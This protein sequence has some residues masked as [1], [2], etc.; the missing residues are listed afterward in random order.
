MVIFNVSF[1]NLYW[2]ALFYG[3]DYWYFLGCNHFG[4]LSLYGLVGGIGCGFTID[5]VH[6]PFVASGVKWTKKL[7][8]FVISVG[9]TLVFVVPLFGLV[10]GLTYVLNTNVLLFNDEASGMI[11]FNWNQRHWFAFW[12]ALL[13]VIVLNYV[14]G[15]LVGFWISFGVP[16]ICFKLNRGIILLDE[17]V[18]CKL[19]SIPTRDDGWT[20]PIQEI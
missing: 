8:R 12:S 5:V 14:L 6:F 16:W 3:Y 1:Q 17:V 10:E 15:L 19:L 4:S 13:G 2:S 9:L 18:Y 11:R 20:S 7:V